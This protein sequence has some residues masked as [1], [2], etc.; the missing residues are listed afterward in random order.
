MEYKEAINWLNGFQQFGVKL[1][2]ERITKLCNNLDNPQNNYKLI[3]V[4][5]TNGKGSVC[6]F[7][8]SIL[9][10][11]GYK[12][13]IYT[14]PHLQRINERFVI[15]GLEIS[16]N[17]FAN[18]IKKIKTIVEEMKK[19]GEPPTYFEILTA[20]AF[21]YF[22]DKNVE[23]AIIEVG[24]GGRFDATNIVKPILTIITNVTL[25]H[26][27]VLGENVGDIAYEKA[28]IIKEG[29]PLITGVQR[30]IL[31]VIENKAK[32]NNSEI[33]IINED[34]LKR[35][36]NDIYGQEF[37]IKG[38]LKDYEINTKLLGRFQGKN[39]AIA[40]NAIENLQLKGVYITE[41]NI[42][43]GIEK[44]TFTGRIE[45]IKENPTIIID[46]AHNIEGF[47]VLTETLKNDFKYNKLILVVGILS[48]KK[49]FEMLK[50]ILPISDII[51]TTKSTNKR[52][53]SPL[54]LK[55]II[56]KL[57]FQKKVIIKNQVDEAIE[58][59]R[60]IAKNKDLICITGSLFTVGEALE[61]FK[62]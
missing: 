23:F 15:D 6:R 22:N 9:S 50:I 10:S 28:G 32:E 34:N 51:I 37:L 48:D 2:L 40:L 59:A 19:E 38:L 57:N 1:G 36:S 43:E 62:N 16:E 55:E 14:S 13:G 25:E 4:G 8:G 35:L 56:E 3:H 45:I 21:Q 33:T 60:S 7:L 5:G 42:F 29:I 12:T 39:I 17:D 41:T 58:Y 49:I 20:M 54:K 53:F 52:A 44:T 18:F 61:Y 24:L 26:Q 31:R 30:D 46:G 27:D 11:S 47:K